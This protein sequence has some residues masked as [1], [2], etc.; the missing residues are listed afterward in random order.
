[1]VEE[2]D[3]RT[4]DLHTVATHLSGGN[5]QR[6]IL[7]RDVSRNPAMLLACYP[8]RGLDI[9]ATEYVHR[10][11]L[12]V[13]AAGGGILLISEELDEIL[14]L[15]DRVAVIYEGE[16]V[17]VLVADRVD[18]GELGLLMAGGCRSAAPHR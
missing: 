11:L 15:S 12:D 17:D 13:R 1:M 8:T 16:I 2:Y 9:A 7:A 4:P 14:N 10:R 18:V 3:I 5:I 6:L